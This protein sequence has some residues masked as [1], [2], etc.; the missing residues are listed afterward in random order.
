MDIKAAFPS[1]ATGRLVVLVKVRQVDGD[2]TRWTESFLFERTVEMIIE[3][4]AM[5]RP[6][7]QARV[8]QCSPVSPIL[9]AILILGLIK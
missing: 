3:G 7:V 9:F 8:P 1:V 2:L 6:R 4:N 5:K